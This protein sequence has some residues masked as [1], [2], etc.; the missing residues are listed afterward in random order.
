MA[1]TN[2]MQQQRPQQGQLAA[3]TV[4]NNPEAGTMQSA[5]RQN[6]TNYLNAAGTN[7]FGGAN[8]PG[9][10]VVNAQMTPEQARWYATEYNKQPEYHRTGDVT[11]MAGGPGVRVS[12]R[13]EMGGDGA[14]VISDPNV[15]VG[16]PG[17]RPPIGGAGQGGAYDIASA[18]QNLFGS[19]GSSV[20]NAG[21]NSSSQGSSG[22]SIADSF[23]SILGQGGYNAGSSVQNTQGTS[24]TQNTNQQG[25]NTPTDTQ[26]ATAVQLQQLQNEMQSS[27]DPN[28]MSQMSQSE[29]TNMIQ[30][31]PMYQAQYD[32][33]LQA[34]N[35]TAAAGGYL[36][37]GQS[38]RAASDFGTSLAGSV[39]QSL[40]SN[41]GNLTAQTSPLQQQYSSQT[42]TNSGVNYQASVAPAQARSSAA[43]ATGTL[44]GQKGLQDSINKTQASIATSQNMTNASITNANNS[45]ASSAS[46]MG[47][48]GNIAGTVV[49]GLF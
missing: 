1:F 35:R 36:A 21:G 47:G 42:A 2:F 11:V 41:L 34:I 15:T 17:G 37:S 10:G 7:Y 43:L 23:R 22:N 30:Q 48:L 19:A 3:P 46:T 38:L 14:N 32:S 12:G 18:L 39:Y 25:T 27:Y 45:A 13:Q 26:S 33:G 31:N 29:I 28:G 8:T 16:G 9:G 40:L 6:S 20:N 49:G 4:V 44:Q 5:A 24:N